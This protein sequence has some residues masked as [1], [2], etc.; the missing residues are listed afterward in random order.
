MEED[1][2]VDVKSGAHVTAGGTVS[3]PISNIF[4]FVGGS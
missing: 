3:E 4:P 2:I 1:P